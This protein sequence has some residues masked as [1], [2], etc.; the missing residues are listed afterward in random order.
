MV[1]SRN[2][3]GLWYGILERISKQAPLLCNFITMWICYISIRGRLH[4]TTQH[5]TDIQNSYIGIQNGTMNNVSDLCLEY[6]HHNE[7][8]SLQP[9]DPFRA[10]CILS[11]Y[12]HQTFTYQWRYASVKASYRNTAVSLSP[13]PGHQLSSASL[14]LCE[15]NTTVPHKVCNEESVSRLGRHHDLSHWE[16]WIIAPLAHIISETMVLCVN[17]TSGFDE[18]MF[19]YPRPVLASGYCHR[20]CLC[21][22]TNHLLVRT[23]THLFKLGWSN[24]VQRSKPHWFRSRLFWAKLTLIFKV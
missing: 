2:K 23:I 17:E 15:E 14:A 3:H 8:I 22:C 13:R 20:L 7:R 1:W 21:V 24:L 10:K 6:L 16:C 18:W 11:M 5:D 4:S 12:F 19:H 9:H